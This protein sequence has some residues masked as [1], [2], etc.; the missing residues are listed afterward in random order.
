MGPA[1]P[2]GKQGT[3]GSP[4]AAGAKGRAAY[5]KGVGSLGVLTTGVLDT[6]HFCAHSHVSIFDPISYQN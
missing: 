1:G 3:E 4:G 6:K 2:Q 5:I